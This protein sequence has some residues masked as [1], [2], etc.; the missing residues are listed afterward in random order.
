M[1]RGDSG[2]P[3]SCKLKDCETR[4]LFGVVSWGSLKCAQK[5]F[6]GVYARVSAARE[7]IGHVTGV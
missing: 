6:P 3:M 4:K 7:W 2:S 1:C 5:G